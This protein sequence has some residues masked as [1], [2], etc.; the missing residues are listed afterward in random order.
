MLDG[1]YNPNADT[2]RLG[3]QFKFK[4][5]QA[6]LYAALLKSINAPSGKSLVVENKDDGQKAYAKIIEYYFGGSSHA[7][8]AA[9]KLRKT[10]N[11]Y[12]VPV[13]S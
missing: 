4:I 1:E 12:D 8:V 3:M 2:E 5:A 10:I 9:D 6:H 7:C 13:Q 11:K